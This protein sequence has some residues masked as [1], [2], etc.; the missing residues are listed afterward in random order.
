MHPKGIAIFAKLFSENRSV[1]LAF[2]LIL[3]SYDS[4]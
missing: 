3:I 1:T 4:M 2:R